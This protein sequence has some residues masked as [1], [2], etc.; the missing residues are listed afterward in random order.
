MVNPGRVYCH[1]QGA[2]NNNQPIIY[3]MS[4]DQRLDDNWALQYT[5]ELA[6]KFNSEWA[7]VF[8]LIPQFHEATFRQYAFMLEGLKELSQKC[9]KLNIPFYVLSG[10]PKDTIP[11]FVEQYKI[12]AIITD[13]DPLKTK[14]RWK[15]EVMNKVPI[16]FYEVDTHNIV[17]CAEA[18]GKQEFAAYT[19]RPKIHKKLEHYLEDAPCVSKQAAPKVFKLQNINW[20]VLYETLKVN[21][22]IQPISWLKPGEKAAQAVF[23]DFLQNKLDK[24]ATT[25]NDPN[26]NGCSNLS[27]YLH[28][29]HIASQRIALKIIKDIPRSEHTDAFLEELIVRKELSDNYC[30]FND[31]YDRFEGFHPWAQKSLTEHADDKR[32]YIYKQ[33]D[34]ENA[35]THDDLW[36]AAQKE[37]VKTGKMHGFMR[38]YWAKKILEWTQSP[39]EALWISIYLNDKYELD[40][41]DP[42]GYTGC[43]WSVGGVH[44]RAWQERQV[45]GKIRYMNYN[46]CKRKFNV[47]EYIQ[48]IEKI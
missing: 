18:S 37:M 34:F 6:N 41:R 45:F 25:R 39:E 4:R 5:I 28:F 11:S 40:G 26:K 7:V 27:P 23:Q 29:G 42:N 47:K 17:P 1:Q 15:Q 32:P 36:N 13:F 35:A 48:K 8:S 31:N 19:L 38:M 30:F 12:K 22:Q 10:Q 24:Y 2:L 43:A 21:R 14:K 3:W 20:P 16:P 33:E 46:G 44:D 9:H